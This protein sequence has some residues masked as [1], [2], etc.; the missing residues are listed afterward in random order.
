MKPPYHD[1]A[2]VAAVNTAQAEAN[3]TGNTYIVFTSELEWAFAW[4][5]SDLGKAHVQNSYR[6]VPEKNR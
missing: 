1:P 4:I 5:E 6:I 3:D 2:F